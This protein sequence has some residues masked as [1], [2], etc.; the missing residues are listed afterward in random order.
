MK[1][2][3]RRDYVKVAKEICK[4]NGIDYDSLSDDQKFMLHQNIK[5]EQSKAIE[6][7]IRFSNKM[8]LILLVLTIIGVFIHILFM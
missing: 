4:K 3:I 1:H 5:I 6:E 7:D 8:G 2:Y